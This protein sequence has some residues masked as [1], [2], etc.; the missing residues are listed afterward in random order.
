VRKRTA[1]AGFVDPAV[2]ID[3]LTAQMDS[4]AIYVADVGQNQIWS[5]GYARIKSG[6]FLTSGGMGTMGYAIP[7][8]MGAAAAM[9]QR[10]VVAVC[11]DGSFQMSFMEL[12]TLKQHGI[13]IKV[14]VIKNGCLGLV[15]EFQHFSY[16][17]NYAMVDLSGSP[18][19]SLIAKA[20]ALLSDAYQTWILLKIPYP[21]FWNCP[22][23][24]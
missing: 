12:A 24:H 4:D 3:S 7:A 2:F 22:E 15:R 21:I 16:N 18:E 8:A 11:G 14:I 23:R 9:P 10:Q 20:M 5:C 17:R 1:P 19:L 6:N 13:N